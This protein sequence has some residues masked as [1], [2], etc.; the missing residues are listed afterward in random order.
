MPTRVDHNQ[1]GRSREGAMAELCGAEVSRSAEGC[2]KEWVNCRPEIAIPGYWETLGENCSE[3]ADQV[4]VSPFW[5]QFGNSR[6]EWSSHYSQMYMGSLLASTVTPNFVPKHHKAILAKLRRFAGGDDPKAPS[7][8]W[9]NS[10]PP[11][12]NVN[13]MVRTRLECQYLDGVDYLATR[14][15]EL[16]KDLKIDFRRKKEG[17]LEGY[18]AQHL[19]FHRDFVFTMAGRGEAVRVEC[20]IQIA[21]QLSTQVWKTTHEIYEEFRGQEDNKDDWQWN[22]ADRRFIARQ[23]GHMMHLADGLLMQLRDATAGKGV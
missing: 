3:W 6:S 21:T 14:L 4:S 16:G 23:L 15:C 7:D 19:Y 22:P 2:F 10:G 1:T 11:V 13:D 17:R 18:F 20:E 5:K 9:P 8:L 12:P